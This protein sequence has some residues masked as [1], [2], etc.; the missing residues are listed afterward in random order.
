M[1]FDGRQMDVTQ[2]P[3]ELFSFHL[4]LELLLPRLVA[5]CLNSY[6]FEKHAKF[7]GGKLTSVAA[8]DSVRTPILSEVILLAWLSL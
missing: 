8:D 2:F 7:S 4:P 3:Q 6:D 1:C 5:Q